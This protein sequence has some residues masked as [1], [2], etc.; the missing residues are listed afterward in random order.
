MR[1]VTV[2]RRPLLK[3]AV[4]GTASLAIPAWLVV[5]WIVVFHSV[6]TGQEARVA[7]FMSM[8]P[9]FMR[10]PASLTLIALA[11][12]IM[13]VVLGTICVRGNGGA[14]RA[15]GVAEIALGAAL[16]CLL[17]FSLM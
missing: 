7:T 9:G 13:G 2:P 10:E 17:L 8:L 3:W 12:S 5:A 16:T 1:D 11:C 6:D 15:V 14:V 4:A